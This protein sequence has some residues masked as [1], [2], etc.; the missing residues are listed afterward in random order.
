L[1]FFV[2][3]WT[4]NN[5]LLFLHPDQRHEKKYRH[6]LPGPVKISGVIITYNEERNIRECILSMS[7]VVD[8]IVVVDS[9][10]TDTTPE[11]CRELK[12]RF[13]QNRFDGHIEQKNFAMSQATYDHILSLDADE[14]VSDGMKK[15]ILDAKHNWQY[16]GY[17]FNRL[18]NYCGHW[19]RYSWYPDRKL[20]L[21]DRT[22]GKWGGT[23]PH[24]RVIIPSGNIIKVNG[25]ILHFAYQNLEEHFEQVKKFAIIAA[26]AKFEKGKKAYFFL[27]VIINPWY[28]FFRKYILRLGFLD[29]YY[30]FV[31]S[32]LTAYLNFMKYLRLWELNRSGK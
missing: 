10:S 25:D 20:R 31:F 13:L 16:D 15:I 9:Y 5:F 29:G 21:W 2:L 24:D 11:I 3:E 28:K 6:T 1:P 7:E 4:G 14:R 12:V 32:G 22:R 19:L 27:H 23:N 8:E 18:N 30:G 26:H 17:S